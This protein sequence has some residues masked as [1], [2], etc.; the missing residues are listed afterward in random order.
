MPSEHGNESMQTVMI[1][2]VGAL[3]LL[4]INRLYRQVSPSIQQYVQAAVSGAPFDQGGSGERF[5][6]GSQ[7]STAPKP[8]QSEVQGSSSQNGFSDDV[9]KA[10]PNFLADASNAIRDAIAKEL[11]GHL[12]VTLPTEA[13]YLD[14]VIDDLVRV[15]DAINPLSENRRLL[16]E[17]ISAIRRLS[18]KDLQNLMEGIEG[19][20]AINSSLSPILNQLGAMF[21]LDSMLEQDRKNQAIG[22]DPSA[23]NEDAYGAYLDTFRISSGMLTDGIINAATRGGTNSSGPSQIVNKPAVQVAIGLAAD[24]AGLAIA[25]SAFPG[26]NAAAYWL[27]DNGYS[28]RPPRFPRDWTPPEVNK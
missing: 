4:G 19:R 3:I 28:P 14:G 26:F 15:R 13:A 16:D 1:M 22:R 6:I 21:N 12:D 10:M 27:Y 8:G 17:E 23:T 5:A 24:R 9:Q 2:A 25:Q 18:K 20:L 11:K 7:P